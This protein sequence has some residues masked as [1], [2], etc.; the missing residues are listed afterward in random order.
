[1]LRA[2]FKPDTVVALSTPAS[3]ASQNPR[4]VGEG[5]SAR[6]ALSSASEFRHSGRSSRMV[7]SEAS[8]R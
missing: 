6:I 4:V 3:P 1:M 5:Y 2:R 7:R 8:E